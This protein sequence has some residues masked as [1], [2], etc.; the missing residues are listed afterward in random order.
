MIDDSY[1]HTLT[2]AERDEAMAEALRNWDEVERR[3]REESAQA[4]AH[5]TAREAARVAAGSTPLTEAEMA[6][7]VQAEREWREMKRRC[8]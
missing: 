3:W 6:Y 4:L 2:P 8:A 5:Q 7:E 1:P